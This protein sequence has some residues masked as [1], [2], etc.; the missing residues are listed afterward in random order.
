MSNETAKLIIITI[1]EQ[2]GSGGKDLGHQ[3]AKRLNIP[4]F[5]REILSKAAKVLNIPE[6][7]LIVNEDVLPLFRDRLLQ[8]L[9]IVEPWMTYSYEY[10]LF[11]FQHVFKVESEIIRKISA[12]NSAA[13]I[14]GKCGSFILDR[15]PRHI[16]IF[17][18]ADITY[19]TKYIQSEL[20][21]STIEAN[22]VIRVSDYR[23]KEYIRQLTKKDWLSTINYDLCLNTAYIDEK[24]IFE[25]LMNYL[26]KRVQ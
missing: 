2:F 13:I 5:D 11:G 22:K 4:C 20:N 26:N 24:T 12:E 14:I 8:Q 21:I 6:E 17:F 19:R 7:Y 10:P 18:Y 3:L 23:R 25:I 15:S 1:T 16:S 9:S